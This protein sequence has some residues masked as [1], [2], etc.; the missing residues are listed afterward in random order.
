MKQAIVIFL[1]VVLGLPIVGTGVAIIA[2]AMSS[3]DPIDRC[4][5]HGGRW[6]YGA[7]KCECTPEELSNPA[8][9]PEFV[10]YCNKPSPAPK[11]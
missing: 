8:V 10:A 9:K 2:S 7:S 6:N 3:R 11:S 5:D 4:L 1:S